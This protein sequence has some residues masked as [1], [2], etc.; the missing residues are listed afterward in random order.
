MGCSCSHSIPAF[1][2][3]IH[4]PSLGYG[5]AGHSQMA[6]A[7]SACGAVASL[8]QAGHRQQRQ[9][10]EAVVLVEDDDIGTSG[11]KRDVIAMRH[12]VLVAV[13]HLED[14]RQIALDGGLDLSAVHGRMLFRI[15]ARFFLGFAMNGTVSTARF[16]AIA[17]LTEVATGGAPVHGDRHG[18]R[19]SEAKVSGRLP[20]ATKSPATTGAGAALDAADVQSRD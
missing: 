7:I 1:P 14:E 3:T 15:V 11:R 12:R 2:F 18:C 8:A 16:A 20:H 6:L 13:G 5:S 19:N 10:V 17:I 9:D 4:Q